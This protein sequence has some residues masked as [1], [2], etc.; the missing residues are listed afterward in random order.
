MYDAVTAE[1][2]VLENVDVDDRGHVDFDSDRYTAN[3]R[4]IIQREELASA[5]DEIDLPAVDQIFF[6][7]RNPAMPPV[8]KL[9]PEEAA[10]A[11][12]L[13]ESVQT[14]AGDPD[15]AGEST[16]VVGTNPFIIG[17]EGGEGNRFR[18]LINDLDVDCFVLNTGRVGRED[19]GETMEDDEDDLD[20]LIDELESA[21]IEPDPD[22]EAVP[23]PDLEDDV[24]DL[25]SETLA[26]IHEA[27]DQYRKA[28]QI[29]LKL[30]SQEPD[31]ARTY[32]QKASEMREQAEAKENAEQ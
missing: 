19:I 21:R 17:S 4:A 3:G 12:M 9:T 29:Y 25:V 32:L 31:Q 14:S 13:G 26:R 27:Q 11:F 1:S 28:A 30:A 10:V 23:E 20:R 7:T 5:S 24:D 2:A 6:I 15:S 16:R 8:A 18:D 22:M